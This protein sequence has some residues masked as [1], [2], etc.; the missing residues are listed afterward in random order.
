MAECTIDE[1][2]RRVY[3]QFRLSD[4]SYG[5]GTDNAWDEAV[6]LVLGVLR[7][8]DDESSLTLS[9]TSADTEQCLTLAGARIN[10][11]QPLPYLLGRCQYMGFEFEIQ[12]GVIVPR[13]PIGY[14]LQSGLEPWLPQNV[15]RVLDL[16][17]GSGCLGIIAAYIFPNAKVTLLELDAVALEVAQRNVV[18]HGMQDRIEII[19]ADVIAK[20]K[21]QP[22]YDLIISNPPYV[23]AVDM[24]SLPAE[25]RAEPER[26][27]A[28]GADGLIVINA[29]L[30][31]LTGWLNAGGLF[32]GE[33]GAS[34][35]ALQ[36][37]HPE[38]PLIWPDLPNGGEG[39]FILEANAL[40][41]HTSRG[42]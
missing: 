15:E 22:P 26:G 39:V 31:Q 37:S 16:C 35:P 2:I 6:A 8:D 25:F 32:V 23:D 20:P 13:S 40:T 30:Q 10:T 18:A 36:A 28:A 17:S 9:V 38:L 7:V 14:L 34:A 5:H 4:L 3:E 21:L 11:R 33:V 29:I 41:S 19:N 42:L 27:L 24:R 12:P 1:L